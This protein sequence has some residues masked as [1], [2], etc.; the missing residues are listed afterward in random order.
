MGER[1]P[2]MISINIYLISLFHFIN[3]L[4]IYIYLISFHQTS[5]KMDLDKAVVLLPYSV[6]ARSRLLCSHA[7]IGC[8][9]KRN[10]EGRRQ[11]LG[12]GVR[13]STCSIFAQSQ[14]LGIDSP[15]PGA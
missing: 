5:V 7:V 3:Y 9:S 11:R 2:F 13:Q 12:I 10:L 15:F 8:N 6:H 14:L 4:N 1:P